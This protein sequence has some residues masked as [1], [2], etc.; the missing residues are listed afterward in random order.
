M[1]TASEARSEPHHGDRA[2]AKTY[3][4]NVRFWEAEMAA[5]ATGMG[6]LC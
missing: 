3:F 4:C 2:G 1:G 6:G 5:F